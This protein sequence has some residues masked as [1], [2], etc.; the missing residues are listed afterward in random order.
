MPDTFVTLGILFFGLVFAIS[1]ISSI[2]RKEI[3]FRYRR[4][5]TNPAFVGKLVG[6]CALI[7]GIF[8]VISGACMVIPIVYSF[9][10]N[11]N[12]GEGVINLTS[13]VGIAIF[14][15]GIVFSSLMQFLLNTGEKMRQ[16][17][18]S[19]K[20]KIIDGLNNKNL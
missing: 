15:I 3:T 5:T 18:L 20:S 2:L 16:Q 1:G 11:K 17:S 12:L 14:I 9:L 4:G 7:Y 13:G 6:I 8:A 19:E 10:A